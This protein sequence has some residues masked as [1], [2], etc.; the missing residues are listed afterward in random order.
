MDTGQRL[1]AY[2]S[3]DLDVDERT[4]LEAELAGDTALR[5]QLARIR[6]A[7]QALADLPEVDMPQGLADRLDAAL[8][9]ELE[10]V[11]GDELAARRARRAMP[12]WLPA[13]GAAAALALVVGTSVVLSGGLGDRGDDM[14]ALGAPESADM[15]GDATRDMM[16]DSAVVGPVV[17]AS[18]RTLGPDDLA[19]LA[20][21][22]GIITPVAPWLIDNDPD[23]VAL[24]WRTAL[25]GTADRSASDT[26][27]SVPPGEQD[28]TAE[29]ADRSVTLDA[30]PS[31]LP[32]LNLQGQVTPDDLDDVGRCLGVL[33]D[34]ATGPIIPLY[35]ELAFD[36]DGI[37][38]I[39]YLA[40]SPDRSGD[41]TVVEVWKVDR[42]SCDVREFAQHSG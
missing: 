11:L 29:D 19:A 32:P 23:A 2:L 4:A 25:G 36:P 27:G 21:D 30:L 12:R 3:G 35:A 34:G 24:A 38:V 10:R 42:S 14:T 26:D 33:F 17:T 9:P 15:A 31:T 8:A 28:D 5:A 20:A 41:L 6:A 18:G 40:L 39:V 7:D 16:A 37:P 22:P 13:A 1:A